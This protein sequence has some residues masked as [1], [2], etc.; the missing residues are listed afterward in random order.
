MIDKGTKFNVAAY[1][2]EEFHR[3]SLVEGTIE[4]WGKNNNRLHTMVPDEGFIYDK[5]QKSYH[6]EMINA[7]L[8]S[9]WQEG[10]FVFIDKKLSQI[11]DELAKW[12][13]VEFAISDSI[14]ANT[15]YTCVL[16]RSATVKQLLDMFKI[17]T[18][19]EYSI[20]TKDNDGAS[21]HI[22]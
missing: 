19:I 8:E 12:Y 21:I 4:V 22:E 18:D 15:K 6:V 13:N 9:S 5:E 17:V 10:K 11:C 1:S 2:S 3:T 20:H 7:A 14:Q 16:R